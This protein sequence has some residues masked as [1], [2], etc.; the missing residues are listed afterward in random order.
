MPI[1]SNPKW[2]QF[3]HALADGMKQIDAYEQAG[4]P[5]NASAASQLK[6]RPEIQSRIQELLGEKRDIAIRESEDDLDNL[7]AELNR[8]WLIKTLMKNVGIAQKAQQIA[9]ANKAVEMLAQIIGVSFKAKTPLADTPDGE[10]EDT[11]QTFD[12]DK[13][14]DAIGRLAETLP[15]GVPGA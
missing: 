8:E 15:S 5:R 14:S 7:P 11:S 9:P 4:Y 1:L 12:F 6:S 10:P 2:E 13:A 3:A